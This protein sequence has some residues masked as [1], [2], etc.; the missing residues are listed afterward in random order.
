MTITVLNDITAG[1]NVSVAFLTG[2][3]IQ[4]PSIFGSYTLQVRT[5]AQ[6]LNGTSASYTLQATTTTI[7]GLSVL[8]NPLQTSVNGQYTY[9]FTTGS[10]GRLVPGTST[11]SLLFP[12]DISFTQGAPATSRVTVNSVTAQS[13]ALNT[14]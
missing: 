4:N 3:G 5:S 10:R 11:I 7:S 12:D 9:S 8:V 1:H 2:A 14:A 6:P 13:I